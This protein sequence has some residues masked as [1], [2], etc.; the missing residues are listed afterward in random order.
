MRK[1][2]VAVPV[3]KGV[4]WKG[5]GYLFSIAGSLLLGA[6]A[7]PKP[8]APAWHLPALAGGVAV[9]IVGF[10]LRYI[11]HLKERREI[12]SAKREAERT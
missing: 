11:A 2:T 8:D 7:W 12:A 10:C 3:P 4:D 6:I 9:S 5:I 1:E